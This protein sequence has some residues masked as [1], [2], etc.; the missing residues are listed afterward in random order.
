V[1]KVK[2]DHMK[3]INIDAKINVED[4][5]QAGKKKISFFLFF[6]PFFFLT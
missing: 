2:E 1:T 4:N 3:T 5:E 6:S